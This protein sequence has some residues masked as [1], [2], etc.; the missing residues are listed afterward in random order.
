MK[1]MRKNA[2]EGRLLTPALSTSPVIPG[3]VI[4]QE[5][6]PVKRDPISPGD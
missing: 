3:A 2:H 5:F 6:R 1:S 4:F